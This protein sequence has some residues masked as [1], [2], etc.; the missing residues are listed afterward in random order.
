MFVLLQIAHDHGLG[1]L[2]GHLAGASGVGLV[3]LLRLAGVGALGA[4]LTTREGRARRSAGTRCRGRHLRANAQAGPPGSAS[5][6]GSGQLGRA[7]RPITPM[8]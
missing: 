8:M 1:R 3:D 2:G 7:I 5:Q 4:G 6:A